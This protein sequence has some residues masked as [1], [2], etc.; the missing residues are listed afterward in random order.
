MGQWTIS[1]AGRGFSSQKSRTS[2][3]FEVVHYNPVGF[4]VKVWTK[5]SFV[6]S[7]GSVDGWVEAEGVGGG[8]PVQGWLEM[9]ATVTTLDGAVCDRSLFFVSKVPKC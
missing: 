9:N 1:A 6:P 8:A 5:D 4:E 7:D 2:A 3:H